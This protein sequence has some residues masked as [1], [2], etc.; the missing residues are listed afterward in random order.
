MGSKLKCSLLMI[1]VFLTCPSTLL[2]QELTKRVFLR[3]HSF[4]L[5]RSA[6]WNNRELGDGT[7]EPMSFGDG[8]VYRFRKM[9]SEVFSTRIEDGHIHTVRVV[10]TVYSYAP[11]LSKAHQKKILNLLKNFQL[12]SGTPSS[13]A[14][15]EEKQF[16]GAR[17]T[18]VSGHFLVQGSSRFP[19]KQFQF[20]IAHVNCLHPKDPSKVIRIEVSERN[21]PGAKR[22]SGS[23]YRLVTKTLRFK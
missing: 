4:E 7:S 10:G 16:G 23:I 13:P 9:S 21:T 20:W 11:E 3:D 15:R 19:D 22:V 1:A 5:P 18:N 8:I 14:I 2:A 6:Q 12:N 17:C